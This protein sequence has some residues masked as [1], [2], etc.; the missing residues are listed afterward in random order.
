VG[1]DGTSQRVLPDDFQDAVWIREAL[2]LLE[3]HINQLGLTMSCR[4]D[5][6]HRMIRD[7][8]LSLK[9][10]CDGI[11]CKAQLCSAYIY[12]LNY[13]PFGKGGFAEVKD[14]LLVVFLATENVDSDIWLKYCHC[15]QEW[16]A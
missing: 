4:F 6:F 12:G 15:T 7:I 14:R 2:V 11:F 8:R 3:W 10:C 16:R 9:H 13:K 5:K 1:A